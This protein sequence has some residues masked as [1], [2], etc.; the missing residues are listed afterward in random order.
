MNPTLTQILAWPSLAQSDHYQ[1]EQKFVKVHNPANGIA[2]LVIESKLDQDD[3]GKEEAGMSYAK[4]HQ[5]QTSLDQKGAW[6]D[7]IKFPYFVLPGHFP[8]GMELGDLAWIVYGD[9]SVFAIC[10]DVGP[11][12]KIGEASVAV[13]AALGF[14]HVHGHSI[15]DLGIDANAY[16]VLMPGTKIT[17]PCTVQDIQTKGQAALDKVLGK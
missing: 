16:I 3:D 6:L 13:H 4:Y 17:T 5:G 15:A 1:G 2:V 12:R 9:H 7:P 11:E 10:G 8:H 14:N